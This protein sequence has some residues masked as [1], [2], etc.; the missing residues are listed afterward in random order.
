[1]SK[2]ARKLNG[3]LF[4]GDNLYF[5]HGLNSESVDLIYL[6]PPFNSKRLY[7]APVGSKA[8]GTAFKDMWSWEDVDEEY[9][10]KV[11]EEYPFMVQFIQSVGVIHSKAMKAYLVYMTQRFLEMHRI[12]KPTGS[13]YLHCDPTAAHYLKIICDRI[14]GKDNFR[15]EITWKRATSEQKGSQHA[16]RV[17]GSNTDTILFY[18]RSKATRLRPYRAMTDE[19]RLRKFNRIDEHGNRYYDDSSHI[20]RTP[21][22]GARPNLC[23][24]WRG[25]VNPHPSGWRL[26]KERLEEEYQKGNIVIRADGKL[27]RRKY[28]KD[29]R[30]RPAGNLWDDILPVSGKEYCGYPTQKPLMLLRRIIEAS[31]NPGDVVMDPFCG[32]ATAMVAAQQLQR[33]W[34]GIDLSR[35]TAD[36][37]MERLGDDDQMFTNFTHRQDFP[38][39]TD[40][41]PV[42]PTPTVK[43]R[44]HDDQKGRCNACDV[45]M[46]IRHLEIDHIIPK[47]KNGGDYYENY[48]LLC[49]NCN[50]VK[51]DR[52]MEYLMSKIRKRAEAMKFKVSF[53]SGRE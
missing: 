40:I 26:S 11:I 18:A 24:E 32:C 12:L 5:M 31:S 33:N 3:T 53:D 13:F 4:T 38:K 43:Q 6:D 28:E 2:L 15:S 36:L 45:P 52:P 27:Q 48:Q 29:Y 47:S 35:K 23:Y 9:L 30:G 19:E 20:W 1:M 10:E 14:F 42:A 50:R 34:I 25:F 46:D 37:I 44:L 49:G 51:G 7:E 21:N 41:K 22:M 17:W 8:A 39:R 16:P